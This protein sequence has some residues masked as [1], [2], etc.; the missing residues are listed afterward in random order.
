MGTAGRRHTARLSTSR[1]LCIKYQ[2]PRLPRGWRPPWHTEL[3]PPRMN[4]ASQLFKSVTFPLGGNNVFVQNLLRKLS[5]CCFFR[6][7]LCLQ[8][9]KR[10]MFTVSQKAL[11]WSSIK[12]WHLLP[13]FLGGQAM[14][15]CQSQR[16]HAK[17]DS[18][19]PT[20]FM[21]NRLEPN[22]FYM[23]HLV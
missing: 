21:R 23:K 3:N 17:R 6:V 15:L 22:F 4:T 8:P 7:S 20:C 11:A 14:S 13:A 2:L 10:P 16:Q 18:R 1:A 12:C 19:G 5:T 9:T